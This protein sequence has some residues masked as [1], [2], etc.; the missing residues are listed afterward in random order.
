MIRF[1]QGARRF[2]YRVVGVAVHEGSVLLHRADHEPFWSLPGGR[3]EHG[4]TAME[5]IT[6]EMH[7]ELATEIQVIRLL[8]LVES[9]FNYEGLNYHELALYFLIQ[10][11]HG[12]RPLSVSA[13]DGVEADVPLRFRWFPV[14]REDLER[15]PLLP[16]FLPEGLTDLPRSIVHIVQRDTLPLTENGDRIVPAR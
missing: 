13:L 7:E 12:S 16:A 9:F 8:W 14:V 15:L 10:F 4:E 11:P 2:N 1:D 6:R 5:T 3:A